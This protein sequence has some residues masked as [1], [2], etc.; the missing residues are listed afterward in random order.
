MALYKYLINEYDH[1]AETLQYESIASYLEEDY[2]KDHDAFLIGNY[3]IEG[4]ELDALL[5]T[6]T[7]IRILE[8]KNWGGRIIA[9]ENGD[10]KS[11]GRTIVGG[12]FGKNPFVQARTNKSR[13]TKGLSKF[14]NRNLID[15]Q[16]SI[17]FSQR[18]SFD[19]SGLSNTVSLW[20]N[21]CS[22][23]DLSS[24]IPN[25]KV[26]FGEK[27]FKTIPEKLK[28]QDFKLNDNE[29]NTNDNTYNDFNESSTNLFVDLLNAYNKHTE[30]VEMYN[31]FAN[32]FNKI[33]TLNTKFVS[34][35]F[36][37]VYAKTSYLLKEH[38][39][40]KYLVQIVNDARIRINKFRNTE[41][42]SSIEQILIDNY[43][44]DFEA[45]SKFI[46]LV[47]GCDIPAD[48]KSKLPTPRKKEN[49]GSLIE[50]VEYMRFIV[51]GWD[52]KFL[53]GSIDG[54]GDEVKVSYIHTF[55]LNTNC[56]WSYIKELLKED[57]QL[58]LVRPRIK[59]GIIIPE[60]I[61]FEP[62]YLVSISDIA[63]C[64][65]PN[66]TTYYNQLI[67]KVEPEP[68]T[69]AILLGNL[70]GQL[71]DEEINKIPEEQSYKKSVNEF[72]RKNAFNMLSTEIS[73]DFHVK[74]QKQK[75]NIQKGFYELPSIIKEFD[76]S[77]VILEPSFFSQMLGLQGR[78]DLM[79]QDFKFLIEQ[80]S[81]KA[82]WPEPQHPRDAPRQQESHYV[83]MLLYMMLVRY[84]YR[85]IYENIKRD[86]HA[87]IL[88]SKYEKSL[89]GLDWAPELM[90]E[91]IKIR[92]SIVWADY[93]YAEIGFHIF[94]KLTPDSFLRKNISPKLWE[95]Y[96]KPQLSDVL[97]PIHFASELEKKYFYRM[98]KF[99][100]NE[101]ILSKVGSK[102]KTD[103]G[104]ASIWLNNLD[105]KQETGN[106]YSNLNLISPTKDHIGE[107]SEVTL[108]FVR[109]ED[110]SMANFRKG[111]IVI[112]YPYEKG[113]VP[114]ACQTM[115][116]RC[117]VLELKTD[118]IILSLRA[119]QSNAKIFQ[120]E[121]NM[122]WAIEHDFMESSYSALYK[123]VHAFLTT[124]QE[125]RELLLLQRN[126]EINESL[127][128]NG[129][130]KEFDSLSLAVKQAQDF[131]LII[132]PP[133][134][135]KTSYGMLN[136]L[137]EEL[138]NQ[139]SNILITSYTN[140]AVDEICSK[141]LEENIDF[142]RIGSSMSAD[143][144][145]KK[146]M[147]STKVEECGNL[148]SVKEIITQ[149]RV[150]IGTTTAFNSNLSIFS[151]KKFDLAIIDEASQ[152]LEPHLLPILSAKF[153]DEIA[154]KK[155][156][157]IGDHKQL[158]AV[159]QQNEKESRVTDPDLLNINLKNCRLSLFERLLS[160]YRDDPKITYMLTKQGRMHRDIAMFPN[161]AFY[162]NKLE[163]VP[164]PHQE[165][166][167]PT[168]GKEENGIVDLLITRRISFI[169][170][171]S[172][173]E[174]DYV[175]DKVNKAEA[176]VIASIV[177]EIYKM[178]KISFDVDKT[179]GVIVPYR[180]QIAT[181]RNTID[182]YGFDELHNIA[183]DTVERFQGSQRDYIIFGF[184]I[185]K[186]YQLQF[187]TNN[188]FEENGYII[189][190]K[191]NVAMTRARKHLVMVGYPNLLVNNIT[192]FKLIEFIKSKQG[193]FEIPVDKFVKGDFVVNEIISV[194][195][196]REDTYT[197]SDK[198]KNT[199]NK[200][201]V[202]K[203]KLLP[204][205][206]FPKRILGKDMD[207]NL[208]AIG[209]GRINFSNEIQMTEING[210][211]TTLTPDW[212]VLLYC[213]YIMR[214][215]YCSSKNLYES[216][217]DM[218]SRCIND[219]NGRLQLIDIGC[220]PSTCGLS[221]GEVFLS[222]APNMLYT[223]IDVSNA[224][225]SKG[226]EL[227]NETFDNKLRTKYITD[228]KELNNSKFW[229]SVSELP[230][231]IIFNF[232]Y[233]FSNVKPKF[234]E[235]LANEI[236]NTMNMFPLNKYMVI[237]QHSDHD[238]D[239]NSYKVFLSLMKQYLNIETNRSEFSY[240]LSGRNQTRSFYYTI[241]H[242]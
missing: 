16:V 114:D 87:F 103:N 47:Y 78:V 96:I 156:V 141:L 185:Q 171:N 236:I 211:L 113:T 24:I 152:I 74:A 29:L 36:N 9:T 82:D 57:S 61:I 163:I 179:I 184:T 218:I 214:Q 73:D 164:L 188:T 40:S 118:E 3:N 65:K 95:C 116:L 18:A 144:I 173:S 227:T 191:L 234:T 23:E 205:T 180:N 143:P 111:D 161:Y 19:T 195:E 182:S 168:K 167:T 240:K 232:S 223:G 125:R 200:I 51:V 129:S 92:N 192:Y 14:L 17:I 102:Q 204:D 197:V 94:D 212:Q 35:Q 20:L 221:F 93:I 207:A 238:Q 43:A 70:A 174:K 90:F 133:G 83:Q 121:I 201:I 60:L 33:I 142:I 231:L 46:A 228:I 203:I 55:S 100:A 107:V 222:K 26:I 34:I 166:K 31:V 177:I 206:N 97:D 153:S 112:L 56:C 175:S 150:I 230:S 108:R 154:V 63:A 124:T 22:N 5:I 134:T 101:H 67:K 169:A 126:P 2:A 137:K 145:Y 199:F 216:N 117:S 21:L 45:I 52:D 38:D 226:R 225:K 147:L 53:Y 224:M 189:D 123:G 135:G 58:N 148:N 151:L 136:T 76:K 140:R 217:A 81:G 239:I 64:F 119:P 149:T 75:Y 106:I 10:W 89:C 77:K 99:I 25:G 88:Y 170:V 193:Y 98:M 41:D 39:A 157:M 219:V 44:Y 49:Y 158:P 27:E 71:L 37:G 181:I 4:V 104:L 196:T 8:F 30:Y 80:K 130:Y 86:F 198:F 50:D 235:Q 213:Y 128:L 122:V 241:M 69:E 229:D 194:N 202:E 178:N 15:I 42:K 160:K 127:V 105:D 110:N 176:N 6:E 85:K 13:T 48:I 28:I 91:A 131:F 209:Y 59:D 139:K 186:Y 138:T 109:R 183:I 84:N 7:Q 187:L 242:N 172:P 120:K 1:N 54:Y 162:E 233:F 68:T 72:F 220:G 159:V 146:Y 210:E 237:I 132:G 62:D 115:I 208:N 215:H 66:A 155:F 12:A 79:Q 32:V 11:N 165:E 190:R